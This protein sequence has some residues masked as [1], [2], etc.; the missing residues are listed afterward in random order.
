M[1]REAGIADSGVLSAMA[2]VPREAFVPEAFQD[3]AYEN[4]ALPIGHGQTV[5][6]PD[7]VA[8]MT[9]AL[10][11]TRRMK[12]LEVGTGS[13]YQTAILAHLTR[14][15]Y[16]VEQDR[17]LLRLARERLTRLR[18]HN[19]TSRIGDGWQGWPEQA[20][21]PRILV[22]AAASGVP[23]RLADQLDPGGVMVTPVTTPEGGQ[24]L[25]RLTRDTDTGRF[26][27]ERLGQVRFVPLI[28]T[29]DGSA[30][31]ADHERS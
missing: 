12:V 26:T 24:E 11:P 5:S 8:T 27:E 7:V 31:R 4:R 19:V 28:S 22:T 23:S 18:C 14:R 29:T 1:V 20:P 16:T 10:A 30:D 2:Q 17:S 3:Q 25:V 6:R 15:V 9:D 21:F 13:G